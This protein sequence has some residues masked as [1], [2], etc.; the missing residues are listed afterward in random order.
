MSKVDKILHAGTNPLASNRSVVAA[1][2][3]EHGEVM[4]K[5]KQRT[6]KPRDEEGEMG[7]GK[8]EKW[9]ANQHLTVWD[10]TLVGGVRV[11]VL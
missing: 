4:A 5:A 3:V 9:I 10:Q 2:V 11:W 7:I 6:N 8:R 1:G